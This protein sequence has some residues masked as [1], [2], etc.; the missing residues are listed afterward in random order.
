MK[1]TILTAMLFFGFLV[2]GMQNVNAQYL[3]SEDAE[4][5]LQAEVQSI[6]DNPTYT[7]N[8]TKDAQWLQLDNKVTLY[9]FVADQIS[10]GTSVEIAAKRGVLTHKVENSTSSNFVGVTNSKG[11]APTGLEQEL[12]DLLQQ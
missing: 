7:N 12:Y 4:I 11:A 5:I 10:N 2:L 1:K 9:T 6:F 8:Q 3:S